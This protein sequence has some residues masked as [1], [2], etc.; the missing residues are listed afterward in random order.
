MIIILNRTLSGLSNQTTNNSNNH[1]KNK[2][3]KCTSPQKTRKELTKIP[4]VKIYD[5]STPFLQSSTNNNLYQLTAQDPVTSNDDSQP[6][7]PAPQIAMSNSEP[8]EV[9]YANSIMPKLPNGST[10]TKSTEDDFKDDYEW[11]E[12][13]K[14]KYE[15]VSQ[16]KVQKK[17]LNKEI[18]SN[19]QSA[20]NSCRPY[21]EIQLP[22]VRYDNVDDLIS[23]RCPTYQ[24]PHNK[25]TTFQANNSIHE[26]QL[27]SIPSKKSSH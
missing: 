17:N 22:P 6:F 14:L 15:N 21:E 24:T 10:D 16:V 12:S 3:S 7:P 4:S 11:P 25:D 5:I 1:N 8:K 9:I 26:D 2:P 19:Y 27:Y 18:Y 13:P 23:V 20:N